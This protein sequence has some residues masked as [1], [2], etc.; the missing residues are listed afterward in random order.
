MVT[1]VDRECP[2]TCTE[3]WVT[4]GG[5]LCAD[6]IAASTSSLKWPYPTPREELG[7]GRAKKARNQPRDDSGGS[8]LAQGTGEVTEP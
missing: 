8:G 4:S 1:D 6:C 3:K 7:R 5:L 2:H